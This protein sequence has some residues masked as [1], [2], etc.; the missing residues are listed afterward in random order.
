MRWISQFDMT[1]ISRLLRFIGLTMEDVTYVLFGDLYK[2]NMNFL[3]PA[4]SVLLL[5]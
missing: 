5:C 1:S 4:R 3:M 2:Q